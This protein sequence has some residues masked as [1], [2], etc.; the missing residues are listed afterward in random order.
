LLDYVAG[1]AEEPEPTAEKQVK[2]IR[3]ITSPDANVRALEDYFSPQ[4][5][6]TRVFGWQI[7]EWLRTRG[8]VVAQS[9]RTKLSLRLGEH[10]FSL[11]GMGGKGG[12]RAF[13]MLTTDFDAT[14]ASD[15]LVEDRERPGQ[16]RKGSHGTERYE[17]Y[18]RSEADVRKLLG[19]LSLHL[20]AVG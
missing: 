3:N 13:L 10:K 17:I 6:T 12:R 15:L 7:F 9:N 2:K 18:L 20:E 19:F 5:E 16:S 14:S 4:A 1:V 11:V 8:S